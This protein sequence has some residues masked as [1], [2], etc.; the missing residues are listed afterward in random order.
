MAFRDNAIHCVVGQTMACKLCQY[1]C[2]ILVEQLGPILPFC[3][4]T[5]SCLISITTLD[6]VAIQ[7][8]QDDSHITKDYG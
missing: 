8:K 4:L 2:E 3:T 7:L 6:T 1:C 5:T